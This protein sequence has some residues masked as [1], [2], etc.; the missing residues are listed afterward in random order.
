MAKTFVSAFVPLT[1]GLA[2]A[3]PPQVFATSHTPES[4]LA[5]TL[6]FESARVDDS[7]GNSSGAV[8][9]N[10]CF[11]LLVKLRNGGS[12][13]VTGI[14]ATLGT[15]TPGVTILDGSSPW[16]NLAQGGAD[17]DA[18]P[19][20]LV[21]T[22][23][24][25]CGA[26]LSFS[27]QV[28]TDQGLVT[29]PF[30]LASSSP[31]GGSFSASAELAIPDGSSAGIDLP[32]SVSG[33]SGPLSKVTA[34]IHLLHSFDGD[35]Q[36]SLRGPDTTSVVLSANR[37]GNGMN[38]GTDC[39]ANF[40]DTT[41]DDAAGSP[42]SS[43]SGE[44]NPFVGSWRPDQPLSGFNGKSGASVNGTWKLH[45]VDC[46]YW[47]IGFTEC[48]T[49]TLQ[50]CGS[51]NGSCSAVSPEVSDDGLRPLL[52]TE[53]GT[54]VD[55]RFEDVSSVHANLYVSTSP[56]T[57]P[58]AVANAAVGRARC[59]V[60]GIVASG[61]WSQLVG[62]DPSTGITGSVDLLCFLVTA[63][64]GSATEGSL[65]RD[66]AGILRTADASCAP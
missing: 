43:I 8:D 57:H 59:A 27:L 42:I 36:I 17:V 34:A 15:T 46:C 25:A 6:L 26:L 61:G 33:V 10:E 51:S 52:A 32:I 44:Q 63:D 39:P 54:L 9:P 41:F 16:A 4:P 31:S 20:R 12:S 14:S 38:F 49:V 48:A 47:D 56:R 29:I 35:L 37:G 1:L 50:A 22:S 5:P 19:F 24:F 62:W 40:N 45:V 23:S 64:N 11:R 55:L 7:L 60:S 30:N 3:A 58:F 53:N 13:S 21:T 66:S 2:L 28:A 18:T 65:G